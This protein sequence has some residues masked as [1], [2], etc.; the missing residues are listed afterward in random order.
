MQKEYVFSL[1]DSSIPPNIG[2]KANRLSLLIAKGFAVP[3]AHVCVWDAYA[4]YLSDRKS[5]LSAVRTEIG[6][7]LDLKKKYAIRSS[8][9]FEDTADY[10]LAG[11]FDTILDVEGLDYI[12]QAIES[13]WRSAQS[14]RVKAYFERHS[15]NLPDLQMAVIIQEMVPAAL[16]GISFSKNPLTGLTETI[17]EAIEG[18]GDRLVQEGHTPERWIYKWGRWVAA[19]LEHALALETADQ[20]VRETGKIS[21]LCQYPVDLEWVYDGKTVYWVQLREITALRSMNIYSN[22]FSKEF[23]PGIIKPLVWSINIPL[24]IGAWIKLFGELVGRISIKP[25]DL[26]KSFYYRAYFNMGVI[27]NIFEKLGLPRETIELLMGAEQ[28]ET[29]KPSAKPTLKTILLSPRLALFA[30]QKLRFGPKIDLFLSRI[31]QNRS[32]LRLDQ[33]N[34]VQQEQ[35]ISEIDKLF[36]IVQDAAYYNITTMLLAGFYI[37]ILKQRL[38]R[39]DVDFE[40]FD[41]VGDADELKELDPNA[42]LRELNRQYHTLDQEL[43]EQISAAGYENLHKVPKIEMFSSNIQD[44]LE[45]FGHLSDSSNDFSYISWR[46]NPDM[47]LRMIIN[48]EPF[49]ADSRKRVSLSDLEP[50]FL[51]RRLLNPVYQRARRFAIY[52]NAVGYNYTALFSLFRPLFLSLGTHLAEKGLIASS[53]DIFYLH[54]GE[55]KELVADPDAHGSFADRVAQRKTE[56]VEY[57]H[58]VLP[59][60]IYGDRPPAVVKPDHTHVELTGIPTSGGYYSGPARVVKGIDDFGKIEQGDV[61]II[62]YSDVGWTPL[63]AKAGAVISESGG[64]LSHSSIIAREYEIPAVVSV[65]GITSLEDNVI[66]AV[67]GYRGLVAIEQSPQH[68]RANA[69]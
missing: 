63:F 69:R 4:D 59:E 33:I 68:N 55:I 26:A 14:E 67:D 36:A 15:L 39:L 5:T 53:H 52:R 28:A 9:T 31:V 61:L 42:K 66:V 30:A 44:F 27:G 2:D 46:E 57:E 50:T 45:N 16:S 64:I 20:I 37:G 8:A 43:R 11:Q 13:V 25:N 3:T 18:R 49:E 51:Q 6:R 54:Y 19:P 29:E 22:K 47:V 65:S 56:I 40:S 38:N 35:L 62:P 34:D 32:E 21:R 60:V 58:I 17:V 1:T 12:V 7:K 41:L 23:L 48:N 10:S 24:V